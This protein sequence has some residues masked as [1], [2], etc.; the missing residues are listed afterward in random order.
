MQPPGKCRIDIQ[1]LAAHEAPRL[2][3]IRLR[4]LTESPDAFATTCDEAAALPPESWAAQLQSMATFL[5][6]VDGEDVGLV[7]GAPDEAR[8]DAAW[9]ISMWVAPEVRGRGVGEALVA[10][11]VEWARASGARR[12][13]LD[14]G[15]HNRPAIA[16]YARMGFEPNG[17]T[18]SLPAPRRHIR[19]HQRELRL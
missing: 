2:R 8:T 16:L 9:L 19:E 5:A 4:A 10:A 7:R 12:L 13:L 15:D 11:V 14:V 17:T 18:G 3:A 6:L 1:R